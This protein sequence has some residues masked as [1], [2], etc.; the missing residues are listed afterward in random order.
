[1]HINTV[2]WWYTK[3]ATLR[4]ESRKLWFSRSRTLQELQQ[5]VGDI[6][7]L[8][9]FLC[10]VS[11]FPLFSVCFFLFFLLVSVNLCLLLGLAIQTLGFG[12]FVRLL[13]V[14]CPQ[15]GDLVHGFTVW[16]V[17]LL[18]LFWGWNSS[19]FRCLESIF[20]MVSLV[21][22]NCS[23]LCWIGFSILIGLMGSVLWFLHFSIL[24]LS[25]PQG[26]TLAKHFFS[27]IFLPS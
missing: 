27:Y 14:L 22:I 16:R 17:F 24:Q 6:I 13:F 10:S 26:L 1:M 25:V 7:F 4:R 12:F 3:A 5:W 20:V 15:L 9:G 2:A 18:L 23:S 11:G 19:F 21:A 8:F